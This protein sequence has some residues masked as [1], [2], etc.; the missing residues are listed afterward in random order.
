M[1]N[2]F[3]SSR[4]G[5]E[6]HHRSSAE[7]PGGRDHRQGSQGRSQQAADAAMV[8]WGQSCHVVG[9]GWFVQPFVI[10]EVSC[11]TG[12]G[13]R[14]QLSSE[15]LKIVEASRGTASTKYFRERAVRAVVIV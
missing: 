7:C 10:I 8:G 3:S 9:F 1:E 4:Q 12:A 6:V 5:R 11:T 15:W 2:A 13:L 14:T